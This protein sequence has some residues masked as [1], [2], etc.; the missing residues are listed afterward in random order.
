MDFRPKPS[1]DLHAVC[2]AAIP[3]VQI[4]FD[5]NVIRCVC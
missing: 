5:Y 2:D 1:D 3:H 4:D